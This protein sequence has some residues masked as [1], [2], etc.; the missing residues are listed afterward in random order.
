MLPVPSI[1]LGSML[2]S[3]AQC[4][5]GSGTKCFHGPQSCIS[6]MQNK[7]SYGIMEACGLAPH[8]SE[9]GNG[10]MFRKMMVKMIMMM[11]TEAGDSLPLS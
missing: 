6:L 4:S 10:K 11:M 8:S 5:L 7:M 3:F 2:S 9:T 1:M